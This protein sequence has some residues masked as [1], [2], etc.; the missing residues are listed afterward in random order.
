MTGS[1]PREGVLLLVL[2]VASAGCVGVLTGEEPLVLEANA[3]SVS[4]AAQ[5]DAGYTETRRT[6]QE[7]SREVTAAGQ[8][9]EV[10]VTNH[11]AEYSRSAS[12]GPLGEGEFARF[13]VLS[14]PAV[15]VFGKTFNPVGEMSNREL[16]EQVQDRYAG[17]EN[18]QPAG[19]R[20]VTVLGTA[21]TVSVFTGDA[22][23]Q[24]TGQSVELTIHVTKL[25]DG[26]DFV[27]A[28]AV[29]PSLLKGEVDRVDTMLGGI[30]HGSG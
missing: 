2:L 5:D 28:I 8:T 30:Q 24:G 27:V 21:R 19:E 18:V 11:L 6:T 16:V 3:V 26:P 7:L 25:R 10:Q 15:E 29:H 9:R 23:L 20:S 17:L 12:A 22:T 13:I 4:A 14:T 1:A